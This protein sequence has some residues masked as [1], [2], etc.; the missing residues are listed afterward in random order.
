MILFLCNDL[1]LFLPAHLLKNCIDF[2]LKLNHL[3]LAVDSQAVEPLQIFHA[4]LEFFLHLLKR[5]DIHQPAQSSGLTVVCGRKDGKHNI[6]RV[7][8]YMA[9]LDFMISYDTL[10]LH[11]CDER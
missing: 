7:A 11:F 6:D 5:A 10:L 9:H 4:L 1:I 3:F 8:V 2:F